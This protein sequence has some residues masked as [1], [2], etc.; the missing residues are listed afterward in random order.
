MLDVLGLM[1]AITF[2]PHF[3][4][5]PPN[6]TGIILRKRDD[7][8]RPANGL[9]LLMEIGSVT[10]P[11]SAK[12]EEHIVN[13]MCIANLFHFS[14]PSWKGIVK[15][16][17]STWKR[18]RERH[19]HVAEAPPEESVL[20]PAGGGCARGTLGPGARSEEGLIW[21]WDRFSA[22]PASVQRASAWI[23]RCRVTPGAMYSALPASTSPRLP[24]H[25]HEN[26]K[27]IFSAIR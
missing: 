7:T 22:A 15:G 12:A 20:G 25:M 2:Q 8:W 21:P 26:V 16:K 6:V 17:K 5:D 14:I 24:A 23:S 1:Y 11:S 4:Q 10:K 9:S 13:P 27:S 3:F 19:I 18:Q